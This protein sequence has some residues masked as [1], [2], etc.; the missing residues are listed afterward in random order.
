MQ[1]PVCRTVLNHKIIMLGGILLWIYYEIKIAKDEQIVSYIKFIREYDK[2]MSM[3]HIKQKIESNDFV[4]TYDTN[5][6]DVVEEING[7]DKTRA[8]RELI[9]KLQRAGAEI[10][11][12]YNGRIISL[13]FLDNWLNSMD[14]IK[15]EV[16]NDIDREV[17]EC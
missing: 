5:D 15:K 7:I 17:Y 6:Y 11:I 4:V 9:G 10:T 13:E 3:S 16:E 8:F 2:S 14:E 12:Y 1:I